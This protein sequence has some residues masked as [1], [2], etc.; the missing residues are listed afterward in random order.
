MEYFIKNFFGKLRISSIFFAVP[1]AK[2][3][4]MVYNIFV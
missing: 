3:T 4:K 1:I 2:Y